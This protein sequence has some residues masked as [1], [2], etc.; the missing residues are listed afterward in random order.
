MNVM[1]EEFQSLQQSKAG[2]HLVNWRIFRR[3]EDADAHLGH[4]MLGEGQHVVGGRDIDSVGPCWWVGVMVDDLQRW[5]NH[6]SINKHA[7]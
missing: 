5:G 1:L 2:G 3:P 7:Q 6:A 4:I